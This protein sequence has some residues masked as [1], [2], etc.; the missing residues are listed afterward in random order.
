[1]FMLVLKKNSEKKLR[2]EKEL[3]NYINFKENFIQI[4]LIYYLI[5]TVW[6][7]RLHCVD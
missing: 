4:I 2:I 6:C 7:P 3:Y 5:H 1:M